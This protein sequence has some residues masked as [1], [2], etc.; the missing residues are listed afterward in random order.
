MPPQ[1]ENL[2]DISNSS[3]DNGDE[4]HF[5]DDGP[6]KRPNTKFES[7]DEDDLIGPR[8]AP[9]KKIPVGGTRSKPS[10]RRSPPC[11]RDGYYL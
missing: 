1:R 3:S 8:V 6:R 7:S 5:G 4:D 9:N 2:L 10:V 11:Y